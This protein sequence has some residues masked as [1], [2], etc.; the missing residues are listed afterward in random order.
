MIP[1][2]KEDQI[3]VINCCVGFKLIKLSVKAT[4]QKVLSIPNKLKKSQNI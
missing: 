4:L 1:K 2:I 3:A